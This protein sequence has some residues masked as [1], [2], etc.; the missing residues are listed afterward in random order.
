M[1]SCLAPS[2]PGTADY[3]NKVVVK[4]KQSS[5]TKVTEIMT[6]AHVLETVTPQH[7]QA[8]T[9]PRPRP[10]TDPLSKRVL[11]PRSMQHVQQVGPLVPG[12][13]SPPWVSSCEP[14]S[15]SLC[16]PCSRLPR[17]ARCACSVLDVMGLMVDKNFRHVPVVS[18]LCC[19]ALRCAVLAPGLCLGCAL[20]KDRGQHAWHA[21]FARACLPARLPLWARP[22]PTL[23]DHY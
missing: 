2:S 8:Q 12:P 13:A 3:L 21:L 20:Q 1:F 6:P 23:S 10:C 7:R 19:A 22:P 4:G 16:R 5:E 17:R 11:S 18:L 15:R 14:R 9:P